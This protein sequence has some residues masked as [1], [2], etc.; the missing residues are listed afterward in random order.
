[1]MLTRNIEEHNRNKQHKILTVF[2]DMVADILSNKELSIRGRKLKTYLVF[3]THSYFAAPK[4][5]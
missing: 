4:K 2:D 5:Y 3:F 1:M